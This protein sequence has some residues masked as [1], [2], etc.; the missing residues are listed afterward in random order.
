MQ[1][2]I[3]GASYISPFSDNKK[4]KSRGRQNEVNVYNPDPVPGKVAF[5]R[6]QKG[7]NAGNREAQKCWRITVF[8]KKEFVESVI[9]SGLGLDEIANGARAEILRIESRA[10]RP[11]NL[12]DDNSRLL[13]RVAKYLVDRGRLKPDVLELFGE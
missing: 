12:S 10:I 7:E 5:P 3:A 9:E 13:F 11:A 6:Q 4:K 1:Q 8:D 2:A